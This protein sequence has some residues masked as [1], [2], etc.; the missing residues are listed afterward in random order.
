M[1]VA[2]PAL[3]AGGLRATGAERRGREETREPPLPPTNVTTCRLARGPRT[4][5]EQLRAAP[6]V[7][8]RRNL[9]VEEGEAS[10]PAARGPGPS[11]RT[12]QA[13]VSLRP[14]CLGQQD[15]FPQTLGGA[16]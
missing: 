1:V 2:R 7:F 13:T 11:R 3:A 10:E 6:A 9:E 15:L 16:C 14:L 8:R 12:G 5:R 4:L